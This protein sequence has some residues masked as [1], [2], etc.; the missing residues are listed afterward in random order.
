M[1]V[2]DLTTFGRLFQSAGAAAVKL[3]LPSVR[4][5]SLFWDA[6]VQSCYNK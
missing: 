5:E 3:R 4:I 6:A 2:A 1:L